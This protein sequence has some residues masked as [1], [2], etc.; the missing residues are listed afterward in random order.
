M[1]HALYFCLTGRLSVK[2]DLEAPFVCDI[3]VQPEHID[4]LG[5][6]NN[7][8]YVRW[9]ER[10]AWEHSGSL[11][12]GLD[13]YQQLDRAMVVVRHEID[14]LA[15]AYLDEE[16]QMATW[17]VSWDSRLRMSRQFQL[18]RPSDGATLLRAHTTFACVELSSGRPRRMPREFIEQYGRAI[19][20]A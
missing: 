13:E 7:A 15:A 1:L 16:L 9:L 20:G 6:V 11:G 19:V 8:V 5:H 14:Y 3:R 12:L 4:E 18:S 17:I 10:C 2:W